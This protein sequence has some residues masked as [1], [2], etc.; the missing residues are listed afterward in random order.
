M[1][2]K[3]A[4]S[5]KKIDRWG[6]GGGSKKFFVYYTWRGLGGGGGRTG[7]FEKQFKR[8]KTIEK[9]YRKRGESPPPTPLPLKA[10]YK[11]LGY[12]KNLS[13]IYVLP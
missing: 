3:Q 5:I 2:D 12:R 6:K 1:R 11:K 7:G 4:L 8:G 10:S 13:Y 9:V